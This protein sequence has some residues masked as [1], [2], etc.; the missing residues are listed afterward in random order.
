MIVEVQ[1]H[2]D[3]QQAITT[4]LNLA[5]Q[6]GG[7]ANTIGQQSVGSVKGAHEDTA[8]QTAEKDLRTLVE[9]F[10]NNTSTSN[11]FESINTIYRD[12]DKD[13]DLKNW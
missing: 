6:Y 2:Q 4:L 13:P 12:A 8:L 3:Y 11:L 1:G 7:H 9:R 5:E 10:A